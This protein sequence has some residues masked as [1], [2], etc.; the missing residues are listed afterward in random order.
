MRLKP[1]VITLT[2][3]SILKAIMDG[4]VYGYAIA[5]AVDDRLSHDGLIYQAIRPLIN[6]GYVIR[7][8][9]TD[10]LE[11]D[12]SDRGRRLYS[13]TDAGRDAYARSV[14]LNKSQIDAVAHVATI[15]AYQLR[16]HRDDCDFDRPTVY[17]INRDEGWYYDGRPD[18]RFRLTRD[19]IDRA[20]VLA[21]QQW[22]AARA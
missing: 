6:R 8:P 1:G 4:N 11:Q 10:W 15:I 14:E 3:A 22:H 20:Y 21:E 18:A 2:Q 9:D 19:E 17:A 16:Y 12:R 7:L 5:K 13:I